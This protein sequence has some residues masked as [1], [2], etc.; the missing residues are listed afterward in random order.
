VANSNKP[1]GEIPQTAMLDYRSPLVLQESLTTAANKPQ[2]IDGGD[3]CV[4]LNRNTNICDDLDKHWTSNHRST[5]SSPQVASDTPQEIYNEFTS[6]DD[7]QSIRDTVT[8][9]SPAESIV[10]EWLGVPPDLVSD[11]ADLS[12]HRGGYA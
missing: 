8:A 5:Q 2:S 12:R 7:E 3:V 10:C 11:G 1:T 6:I 9:Y 4:D